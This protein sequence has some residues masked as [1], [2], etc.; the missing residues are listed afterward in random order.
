MSN[1]KCPSCSKEIKDTEKKIKC[2]LCGRIMHNNTW[3]ADN[4][5]PYCIPCLERGNELDDI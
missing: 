5:D 2:S 4:E 1:D 3:C